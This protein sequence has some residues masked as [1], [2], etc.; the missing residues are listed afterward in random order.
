MNRPMFLTGPAV[1]HLSSDFEPWLSCDDCF[2]QVDVAIEDFVSRGTAVTGALRA[3]LRGCPACMEEA[4][5]L[6]TMVAED[7][8]LDFERLLVR[9]DDLLAT[10]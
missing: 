7:A 4:R 6:V 3:H 2:D 9:F 8:G 1:A 10:L 5:V